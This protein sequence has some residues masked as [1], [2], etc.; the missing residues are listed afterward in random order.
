MAEPKPRKPEEDDD[1]IAQEIARAL[2]MTGA[3]A[4]SESDAGPDPTRVEGKLKLDKDGALA[5]RPKLTPVKVHKTDGDDTDVSKTDRPSGEGPRKAA[6]PPKRASLRPAGMEGVGPPRTVAPSADL[7]SEIRIP[8]GTFLYGETRQEHELSAFRI[9][10]FPVT[11]GQY[12]AFVRATGHRPPL[13]WPSGQMQEELRNH[14]VVG[15]DYFD[16]LAFAQWKGKDLPFEDEWERAARG[17]DGRTFP[18]GDEND[19]HAANTA[20]TSLKM[21]VP[22]TLHTTNVSPD[23]VRDMVGNAWEITHSPAQGGGVVVRGGSWYDFA[24]YAK[25]FFRF[26]T[27]PDARNGT[28]GFRCCVREEKRNDEPREVPPDQ[29]EAEIAARTGSQPPV[30]VSEFSAER[31]DLVPDLR[32]LRTMEAEIEAEALLGPIRA[33]GFDTVADEM[34]VDSPLTPRSVRADKGGEAASGSD[35]K[36][37]HVKAERVVEKT[38]PKKAYPSKPKREV[39]TVAPSDAKSEPDPSG[40]RGTPAVLWVLLGFGFLLLG[41][42]VAVMAN[43]T[44]PPDV[45]DTPFAPDGRA[46][47]IEPPDTVAMLPDVPAAWDREGYDPVIHDGAE[48]E[49]LAWMNEGVCLV[50]FADPSAKEGQRTIRSTENLARRLSTAD[51]RVLLV[52]PRRL[53]LDQVGALQR[54]VEIRGALSRIWTLHGIDVLLDPSDGSGRGTLLMRYI[55]EEV[56]AGVVL[57]VDGDKK[58]RASPPEGTG[59]FVGNF[60]PIGKQAVELAR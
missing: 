19:L 11:N 4:G 43:R 46:P 18:W 50:V 51:V 2:G 37:V 59:F 38:P 52:V 34:D 22:V 57:L 24:L 25:T 31:R 33:P 30:D 9:D 42:V 27:R 14:P 26:A 35:R 13:Y 28:I 17:I 10:K 6:L 41:G 55:G 49:S 8:A 16:A 12:D 58:A 32:A 54:E 15:V 5:D 39:A 7:E 23:G 3:A 36:R 40:A 47:V 20:R 56:P 21:T 60:G 29:V 48:P 45:A 1:P 44:E 53:Y